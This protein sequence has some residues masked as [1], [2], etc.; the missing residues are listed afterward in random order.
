[1]SKYIFTCCYVCLLICFQGPYNANSTRRRPFTVGVRWSNI[2]TKLHRF[3]SYNHNGRFNEPWHSSHLIRVQ[4]IMTNVICLFRSS[5]MVSCTPLLVFGWV[6]LMEMVRYV[7]YPNA[8]KTRKINYSR[9]TSTSS[10]RHLM[11]EAC[12]ERTCINK[13]FH[14]TGKTSFKT[15]SAHDGIWKMIC[16]CE[17]S[18]SGQSRCFVIGTF[19]QLRENQSRACIDYL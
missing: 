18:D 6:L 8:S 13:N 3:I 5:W 2:F 15:L 1:M 11:L 12:E 17:T 19:R 7:E 14:Q 16:F 10:F 9:F 4:F